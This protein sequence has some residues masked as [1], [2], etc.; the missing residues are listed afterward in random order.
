MYVPVSVCVPSVLQRMRTS[1][2]DVFAAGD[3]THFPLFIADDESVNIQHWQMALKQ[4]IERSPK[5]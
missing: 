4:G 5:Y 3:V 2:T 1:A